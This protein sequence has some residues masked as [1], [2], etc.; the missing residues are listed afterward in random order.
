MR[1][2]LRDKATG[3]YMGRRDK[4]C[5]TIDKHVR[6]YDERNDAVETAAK[7]TDRTLVVVP[8][9]PMC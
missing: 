8:V 2:V 5:K 4:W 6:R 9:M 3:E 7:C 1:Y